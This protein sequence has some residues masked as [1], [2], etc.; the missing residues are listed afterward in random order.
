MTFDSAV[1][2]EYFIDDHCHLQKGK[3]KEQLKVSQIFSGRSK[4]HWLNVCPISTFNF[5]LP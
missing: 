5:I 2:M 1:I 4:S 3:K